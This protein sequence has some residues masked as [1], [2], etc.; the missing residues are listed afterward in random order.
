MGPVVLG[1]RGGSTAQLPL[2][3][4]PLVTMNIGI[5]PRKHPDDRT[6]Q[7]SIG[8]SRHDQH[9]NNSR[10]AQ[11]NTAGMGVTWV[12]QYSPNERGRGE[13]REGGQKERPEEAFLVDDDFAA[14][15]DDFAGDGIEYDEC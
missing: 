6:K 7:P 9:E 3:A 5:V 4:S 15:L 8:Q 14:F 10:L 13:Q 11:A 1:A 12:P 2:C